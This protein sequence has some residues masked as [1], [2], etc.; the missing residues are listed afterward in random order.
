MW[1]LMGE[2]E[3]FCC[4][5]IIGKS[6]RIVDDAPIQRRIEHLFDTSEACLHL[7]NFCIALNGTAMRYTAERCNLATLL[8][9]SGRWPLAATMCWQGRRHRGRVVVRMAP[10]PQ[11]TRPNLA[12]DPEFRRDPRV[13]P[14]REIIP[15]RNLGS[16][17]PVAAGLISRA[18]GLKWASPRSSV[19]TPAK[20]LF[21]VLI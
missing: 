16:R 8:P 7:T 21:V 12:R 4:I 13:Q 19:C 1:V 14:T 5:H 10:Q 3:R 15:A 20:A 17:S 11:P 18:L 6:I 2:R 9:S